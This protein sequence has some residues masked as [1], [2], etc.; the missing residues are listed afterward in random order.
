MFLPVL[1]NWPRGG[2][3]NADAVTHCPTVFGSDGAPTRLGRSL[4]SPEPLLSVESTG[5]KGL[6]LWKLPVVEISHPR[7]SLPLHPV[8]RKGSSIEIEPTRYTV[9]EVAGTEF[10]RSAIPKPADHTTSPS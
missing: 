2:G 7:I 6:P 1:P 5:W 4:S 9:C 8:S 10:S 3:A